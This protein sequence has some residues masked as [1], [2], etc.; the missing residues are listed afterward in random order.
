V[1]GPV[2]ELLGLAHGWPAGIAAGL[3]VRSRD[4]HRTL[5]GVY[6]AGLHRGAIVTY[7]AGPMT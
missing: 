1:R 2:V 7:G 6:V 5:C 3:Y 4:V